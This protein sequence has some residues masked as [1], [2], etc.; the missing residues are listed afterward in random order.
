MDDL[1]KL[2]ATKFNEEKIPW[3]LEYGSLLGAIRDGK[4]IEW[5]YDY[6]LGYPLEY[7][8]QVLKALLSIKEIKKSDI[9][10]NLY[11]HVGNREPFNHV[12]V[13]PFVSIK[14]K[15]YEVT[16][17]KI[18]KCINVGKYFLFDFIRS[19]PLSLQIMIVKIN[20]KT[21]SLLC[22]R[23]LSKYYKS[24]IKKNMNNIPTFVPIGYH[25]LLKDVYG[26]NYMIPNKDTST[27]YK[28]G[29]NEKEWLRRNRR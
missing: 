5:D 18:L 14:G 22:Y 2:V 3:W 11:F 25:N 7:A 12:C 16:E 23:G 17:N 15:V 27:C 1:F 13:K 28:G 24:F 6:D 9:N 8:P 29:V 21:Y 10:S 20:M 26:A 19:L 4:R